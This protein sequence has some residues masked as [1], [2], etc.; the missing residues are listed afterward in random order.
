M[1]NT[2]S[3]QFLRRRK[4]LL[5]LPLL[6][7]P[8]IT[9]GFWALGGGT[10]S[11]LPAA[12][13]PLGLNLELPAAKLKDEAAM[14]KLSFYDQAREDSIRLRQ[15]KLNDPY[16]RNRLDTMAFQAAS[17]PLSQPTLQGL[18]VSPYAAGRTTMAEKR[19][20]ERLDA[21]QKALETPVPA[22]ESAESLSVASSGDFSS[23]INR[24]EALMEGLQASSSDDP[25]VRELNNMLEKILDIQHPGRV[26]AGIEKSAEKSVIL[27]VSKPPKTVIATYLGNKEKRPTANGFYGENERKSEAEGSNTIAATTAQTQTLITGATVKLQLDEE[28]V[29]GGTRIPKGTAV[30]GK[31]TLQNER[32]LVSVT[33]IRYKGMLYP[34]TLSVYDLDGLAGIY[35]PGSLTRESAKTAASQNLGSLDL[36]SYDPSLK[37]QAAAAGIQT[38]KGLLF[39]KAKQVKVTLKAGYKVLLKDDRTDSSFTSNIT[40]S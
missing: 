19:I 9:L 39:K 6:T 13:G 20:S 16:Y 12:K 25:E 14:D 36:L 23:D 3:L 17:S 15:E 33:G 38:A 22:K 10:G 11:A 21:L 8:F 27:P 32:L 28:V 1:Q 31:A 40:H 34:V 4:F 37:T 2:H 26:K 29:I 18:N 35:V 24:L 5:M 30:F 7:L